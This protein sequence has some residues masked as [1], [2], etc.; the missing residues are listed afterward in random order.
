VCDP[1]SVGDLRVL[2]QHRR[3]VVVGA[4]KNVIGKRWHDE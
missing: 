1:L 3:T 4:G 2:K